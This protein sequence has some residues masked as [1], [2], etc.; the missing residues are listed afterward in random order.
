LNLCVFQVVE[1]LGGRLNELLAKRHS[2]NATIFRFY[3]FARMQ[4]VTSA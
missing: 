3:A 2:K 1:R 4:Q